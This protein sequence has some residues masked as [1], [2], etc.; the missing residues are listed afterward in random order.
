MKLYNREAYLSFFGLHFSQTLPSALAL[1]QHLCSQSLPA[2][3]AL[4][5]QDSALAKERLPRRTTAQMMALMDFLFLPFSPPDLTGGFGCC[6]LNSRTSER[7]SSGV[8]WLNYRWTMR[9]GHQVD[10]SDLTDAHYAYFASQSGYVT[11]Q[12]S[13]RFHRI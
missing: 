12:T 6:S 13:F 7:L 5:Q 3:L 9:R 10:N 8:A 11:S 1:T 4:S 2:A